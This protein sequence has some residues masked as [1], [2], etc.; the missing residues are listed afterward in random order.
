VIQARGPVACTALPLL[1]PAA[2]SD[3][4]RTRAMC[5]KFNGKQLKWLLMKLTLRNSLGI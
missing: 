5:V 1:A 2:N 4:L 3:V